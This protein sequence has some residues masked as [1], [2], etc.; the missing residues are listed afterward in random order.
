MASTLHL[1]PPQNN[2]SKSSTQH[3][4]D[5]YTANLRAM[6][7]ETIS[8]I[9][10]CA[11]F[12]STKAN[13]INAAQNRINKHFDDIIAE[14]RRKQQMHLNQLNNILCEDSYDRSRLSAMT[15][16][17]N[18]QKANLLNCANNSPQ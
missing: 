2:Y 18:D 15:S 1:S 13:A 12:Q 6:E 9:T 8:L 16:I 10:E 17:V 3:A 5:A 14:I 11:S 7:A 4:L